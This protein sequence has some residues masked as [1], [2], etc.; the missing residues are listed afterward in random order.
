MRN[1]KGFWQRFS[2]IYAD[3][4]EK[5]APT[6]AAACEW[7]RQR[8]PAGANVLELACGTGQFTAPLAGCAAHWEATDFSSA[9]LRRAKKFA[10]GANVSFSIADAT[11]LSL[12]PHSVDMAFM[13]NALHIMPEPEKALEEIRRVLK[14]GGMLACPTFVRGNAKANRM[15]LI[16]IR[17]LGLKVYNNFSAEGLTGFLSSHGWKIR[18]SEVVGPDA[19]P[20]LCVLAEPEA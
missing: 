8:I 18:E 20:M 5:S 10:A 4:M 1:E 16:K 13:A 9:M 6:Y 12:A 14:P 15:H 19:Q 2:T 11:R 7:F 17:I 3:F